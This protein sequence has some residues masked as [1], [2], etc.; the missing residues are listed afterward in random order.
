M[1]EE[2]WQDLVT[3]FRALNLGLPLLG[4]KGRAQTFAELDV[5]VDAIESLQEGGCL[6]YAAPVY[7]PVKEHYRTPIWLP[8][9][10][11]PEDNLI[12]F[13]TVLADAVEQEDAILRDMR[14]ADDV[15]EQGQVKAKA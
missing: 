11:K 13:Q 10:K 7:T 8:C 1:F 3:S 4:Y 6:P 14:T 9:A 5:L 15:V 12:D 2:S